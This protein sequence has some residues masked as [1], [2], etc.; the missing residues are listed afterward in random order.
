M[1]RTGGRAKYGIGFNAPELLAR[2]Q[3]MD[4]NGTPTPA[5]ERMISLLGQSLYRAAAEEERLNAATYKKLAESLFSLY[6]KEEAEARA[7]ALL[8]QPIGEAGELHGQLERW[9]HFLKDQS[10][11]V[12][13][14]QSVALTGYAYGYGRAQ[15]ENGNTEAARKMLVWLMGESQRF[16]AMPGYPGEDAAAVKD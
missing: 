15:L 9:Y 12:F 5:R 10:D 4:G 3:G 6:E 1:Q 13:T 7:A 16:A 14:R 11:Q 2:E 8:E